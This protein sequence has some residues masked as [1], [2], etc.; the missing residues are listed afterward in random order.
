MI[1]CLL[2]SQFYSDPVNSDSPLEKMTEKIKGIKNQPT[3]TEQ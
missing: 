3:N 1:G 2:A